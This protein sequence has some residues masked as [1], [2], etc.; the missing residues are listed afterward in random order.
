MRGND[1]RPYTKTCP[2]QRLLNHSRSAGRGRCYTCRL[3]RVGP[4][5]TLTPAFS[6]WE[7]G[8]VEADRGEM[9]AVSEY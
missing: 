6:Q 3:V 8:M 4:L 9:V 1:E 7:R 5:V 2:C